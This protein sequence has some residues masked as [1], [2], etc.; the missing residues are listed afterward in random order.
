MAVALNAA[1]SL[2]A[3]ARLGTV[4]WPCALVFATA[5]IAGAALGAEAGKAM[6]GQRLLSLFGLVMIGVGLATLRAPREA[7]DPEVRLSRSSAAHLVPRLLG[8]GIGVGLLAG[9][10]GIGGGFLVVPGLILA[11]RMPMANAIGTSLVAVTAFGLTTAAS[12]AGSGLVDWPLALL[13]ISGGIAGSVA[14]SRLSTI[15]APK[16]QLLTQLFVAVV[17]ATG[18]LVFLR[19]SLQS[20]AG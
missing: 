6:D 15:L 7:S 3:H 9:F 12:Y 11:T 8:I 20:V 2:S 4:K 17:V 16:K 18:T 14:G 5:G 13:V 10:F 1:F 19:G